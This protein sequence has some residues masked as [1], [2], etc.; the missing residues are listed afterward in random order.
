MTLKELK[1]IATDKTAVKIYLYDK[2]GQEYI[3]TNVTQAKSGIKL[4]L[5]NNDGILLPISEE[6]KDIKNTINEHLN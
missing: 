5:K 1:R 2:I 4:F 3:L 6:I